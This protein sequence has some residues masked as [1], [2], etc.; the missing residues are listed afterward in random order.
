MSRAKRR[1]R[2]PTSMAAAVPMVYDGYYGGFVPVEDASFD[3]SLTPEAVVHLPLDVLEDQ[4]AAAEAEERRRATADARRARP[5]C[6][7]RDHRVKKVTRAADGLLAFCA[8]CAEGLDV[9]AS[10]SPALIDALAARLA[11]P[12]ARPRRRRELERRLQARRHGRDLAAGGIGSCPL[13]GRFRRLLASSD[14][15][16]RL[17]RACAGGTKRSGV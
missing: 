8:E 4:R 15:A 2:D 17:C 1:S 11:D 3:V 10:T 14:G 5:R 7:G 16:V 13:C 6:D 12:R 9:A